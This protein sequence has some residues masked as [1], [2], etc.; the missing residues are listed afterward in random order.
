M[1]IGNAPWPIGVT[2]VGIHARTGREKI[3]ARNVAHVLN[4]ETQRKYIQVSASCL[5]PRFKTK[6]NAFVNLIK[7][8][9]QCKLP[10]GVSDQQQNQSEWCCDTP[11][12]SARVVMAAFLL[13]RVLTQLYSNISGCQAVDDLL[14]K[15]FPD[16]SIALCQLRRKNTLTE[17]A[18]KEMSVK[19]CISKTVALLD[20]VRNVTTDRTAIRTNTSFW[21]AHQC[22]ILWSGR[23]V[24][25]FT[26]FLAQFRIVDGER[27]FTSFKFIA[28]LQSPLTHKKNISLANFQFLRYVCKQPSKCAPSQLNPWGFRSCIWL[29]VTEMYNH[30]PT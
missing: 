17:I 3:F 22:E 16:W 14:S 30:I 13:W 24:M 29:D 15:I 6:E 20:T 4:D 8:K 11:W 10:V 21:S 23:V 7:R 12:I 26:S 19:N 5:C 27:Q 28:N 9:H 1:A 25:T 18:C 2:M